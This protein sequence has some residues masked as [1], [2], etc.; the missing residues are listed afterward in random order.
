MPV[1]RHFVGAGGLGNCIDP[2]GSDAGPIKQLVGGLQNAFAWRHR[3]SF[4]SHGDLR[5][6]CFLALDWGVTGK[7]YTRVTGQYHIGDT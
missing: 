5:H 4:D 1:E 3:R 6:F 7:Y 2:D